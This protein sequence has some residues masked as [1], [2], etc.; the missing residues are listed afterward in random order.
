MDGQLDG[1]APGTG[2]GV[3]VALGSEFWGS[4]KVVHLPPPRS[5]CLACVDGGG[6]E[7]RLFCLWKVGG[8]P[9]IPPGW[10]RLQCWDAR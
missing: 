5:Y 3:A 10:S 2:W 8:D 9:S 6:V 7:F 4:I 1:I